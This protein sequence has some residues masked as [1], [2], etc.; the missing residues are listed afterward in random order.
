MVE[1][2][3]AVSSGLGPV[4][5]V[6]RGRGGEQGDKREAGLFCR[7]GGGRGERMKVLRGKGS[8][9]PSSS[10]F[11]AAALFFASIGQTSP[12]PW[13]KKSR[14][15]LQSWP[16]SLS[17]SLIAS[18]LTCRSGRPTRPAPRRGSPR[19]PCSRRPLLRR[20]PR[21]GAACP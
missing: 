12:P 13:S 4:G 3:Q 21:S 14:A 6:V 1:A 17:L 8:P 9:S 18:K 20:T 5:D 15:S 16:F 10:Q 2:L 11:L 19:R 7:G